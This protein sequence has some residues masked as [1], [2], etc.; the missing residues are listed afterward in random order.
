MEGVLQAEVT[1]EG[2]VD[3]AEFGQALPGGVQSQ[4]VWRIGI[5]SSEGQWGKGRIHNEE[6]GMCKGLLATKHGQRG[7]NVRFLERPGGRGDQEIDSCEH[8]L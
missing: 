1:K 2:F 8:R 4:Q 6:P 3:R 5:P 7:L